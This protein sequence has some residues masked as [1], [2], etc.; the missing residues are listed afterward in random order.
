MG[1][2]TYRG[3]A[4]GTSLTIPA[5]ATAA[6]T[7]AY[8]IDNAIVGTGLGSAGIPSFGPHESEYTLR[9]CEFLQ[10]IYAPITPSGQSGPFQNTVLPLNP[11]LQ[12]TFP[13]LGLVAPQFE[14]YEFKQLIFYWRPMVTDFNSGTGQAGEVIMVTQYNPADPPFTD[15]LRAKSY[16]MAMSSKTSIP[17]NHGVECDPKLNSGSPGKYIRLGP[18]EGTDDLKQYDWGNL[19]VIVN[20][21][22]PGY[23]GQLLGELWCAYTVT[24]RKPKL[25]V[26]TG[27]SILRDYFESS[28]TPFTTAALYNDTD[29]TLALAPGAA[30]NDQPFVSAQQNRIHGMVDTYSAAGAPYPMSW[31]YLV[32]SWYTGTLRFTLTILGARIVNNTNWGANP[33]FTSNTNGTKVSDLIQQYWYNIDVGTFVGS[34][35]VKSAIQGDAQSPGIL[36]GPDFDNYHVSKRQGNMTYI[37]DVTFKS[38]AGGNGNIID[39]SAA[40]EQINGWTLDITEYNDAFNDSTGRITLVDDA[41]QVVPSVFI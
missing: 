2:A 8:V 16:D 10:S 19:N 7:G 40:L 32:P 34:Q 38:Q 29:A 18:L 5:G 11:G 3:G 14:E 28:T 1:G 41:N 25:P 20:G 4:G 36:G 39:L 12:E 24:L 35:V 9:K 33:L 6:G 17:M 22:P 37:V 30:F 31:R 13:W 21:T 26:T 27:A 23:S 15:T